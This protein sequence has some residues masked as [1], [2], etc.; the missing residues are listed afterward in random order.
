MLQNDMSGPLPFPTSSTLCVNVLQ[1][2]AHVLRLD[3]T[4]TAV[5]FQPALFLLSHGTAVPMTVLAILF[6][7]PAVSRVACALDVDARAYVL[8]TARFE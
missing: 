1:Y 7:S 4:L 6:F 8:A 3:V 5:L 2:T